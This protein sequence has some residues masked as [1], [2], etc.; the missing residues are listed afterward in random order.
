[1][2]A[3]I[4]IVNFTSNSVARYGV[5]QVYFTQCSLQQRKKQVGVGSEIQ[6]LVTKKNVQFYK[7]AMHRR[8]DLP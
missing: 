8:L 2:E 4:A 3:N 6:C 1:M 5:M 7:Q